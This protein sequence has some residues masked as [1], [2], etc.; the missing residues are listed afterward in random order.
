MSTKEKYLNPF[1]DFGFKKL[2][3]SEVNVDILINFLNAI[4]PKETQISHLTYLKTEHI[5][6]SEMDRK[7]VYDVYCENTK[8][9]KFIVELQKARQKFF[10]ERTIFYSTFPIQEQAI[11][12]DWNFDLKAVYTIS[13]LDFLIDDNSYKSK[14]RKIKQKESVKKTAKLMDIETNEIFYDKLTYVQINIPLFVKEKSELETLE[15]KW[16]YINM[17]DIFKYLIF[18]CSAT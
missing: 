14:Q 2:F 15:D 9:E 11:Q 7:V 1:T 6:H 8:G 18:S 12:G 4:L 10:K 17:S 16:F 3:G 5:G 13:I